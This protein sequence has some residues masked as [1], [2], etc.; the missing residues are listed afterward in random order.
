M[1]DSPGEND[2][3][4]ETAKLEL[5]S[6]SLRRRKKKSAERVPRPAPEPDPEPALAAEPAADPKPAA[7]PEPAVTPAPAVAPAPAAASAPDPARAAERAGA[8]EL[9]AEPE[10]EPRRRR[11]L[12]TLNPWVAVGLTGLAV[13]LAGA[14]LTYL[15]LQGCKAVRGTETCGGPGVFVLVVILVLMALFGG[16]L[17]AL[18]K[19][20]QN[21]RATSLLAIGVLCVVVMVT[22]LEEL[23]SAWMFVVVP[24]LSVL[25]YLLAH[26]V[27]T[28]YVELPERG[29]EHDVR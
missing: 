8:A 21:P 12:P 16:V 11:Q 26:W 3:S 25:A 19:V 24:L 4:D 15:S 29:P 5:P 6:L 17:L 1:G 20:S 22:L 13:G 18:S 14:V 2:R 9:A 10:P 7:D 28:R 23:F 27:T